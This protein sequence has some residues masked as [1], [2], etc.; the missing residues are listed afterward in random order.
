MKYIS[1]AQ[2]AQCLDF[3]SVAVAIEQA[4]ESFSR[5][6]A[7]IK[8]RHRIDCGDIKLS[9]M[10][11]IWLDAGLAGEKIYPTVDGKFSFLF[12]LFDT[13]T[14]KALA[15]MEGNE[16]T[17]FRTPALTTLAVS[18]GASATRKL[19]LFGAGL[20]G[21]A[22]LE[23]LVQSLSFEQIDIVDVVDVSLWCIEIS[24]KLG[25]SVRQVPAHEALEDADVIVTVTRSKQP[26]FDG[27]LIKPGA[28]VAAVGTSLP[29]GRELD[30]IVLSRAANIV[31]EWKPQSMCEAGEIVIGKK[32]GVISDEKITD[33]YE[34]FSGQAHWRS[35]PTDIVVFKSVGVG[36]TD[37]AAAK[38]V[39]QSINSSTKVI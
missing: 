17:R 29:N 2:I 20:Q 28:F 12:N 34:I 25:L 21:R 11:A 35:S 19:A 14:G 6:R 33:M 10:G 4:F 1:D 15:V 32:N 26:L 5:G 22:H 3:G 38:L 13:Q 16:L 31:L 36:L 7:A 23:S 39:W 37:L 24:K 27:S 8:P 9:S 18:R 30:D